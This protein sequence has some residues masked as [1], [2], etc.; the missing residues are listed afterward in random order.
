MGGRVP[1]RK[2]HQRRMLMLE[3]VFHMIDARFLAVF[4]VNL[5]HIEAPRQV[6]GAELLEPGVCAAFDECLLGLVYRIQRPDSG[7]L[8]PGF[9]FYKQEQA[10]VS[11]D[12]VHFAFARPSKIPSQDPAS[13]GA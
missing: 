11:C 2:F 3:S 8:L 7:T 13:F 4:R 5:D 10:V 6:T 12:D 1:T 9:Y